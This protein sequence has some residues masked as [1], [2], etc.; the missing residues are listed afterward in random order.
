MFA[1]CTVRVRWPLD[2]A[3]YLPWVISRARVGRDSKHKGIVRED[4]WSRELGS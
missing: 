4:V 2:A 3:D 1:D